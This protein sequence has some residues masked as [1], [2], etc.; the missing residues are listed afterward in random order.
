MSDKLAR[1]QETVREQD[2]IL[3]KID[4]GI[5]ELHE[6]AI[7]IQDELQLQA[8]IIDDIGKKTD[9]VGAKMDSARTSLSNVL[10]KQRNSS[11]LCYSIC[12]FIAFILGIT[13]YIMLS[14]R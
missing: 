14:R 12:L 11:I 9:N 4:N 10:H 5:E 6:Q 1:I 2:E 13:L 3:V 7:K 8:R